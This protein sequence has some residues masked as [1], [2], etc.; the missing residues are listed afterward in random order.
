MLPIYVCEDDKKFLELLKDMILK[1]IAEELDSEAEIVCAATKPSEI[2]TVTEGDRRPALY[3]LDVDLGID[4]MN[5]IELGRNIRVV[6]PGAYIVM[7]TAY[8]DKAYWTYKHRIGAKGYVLK[9][10]IDEVEKNLREHI[11]NAYKALSTN[12]IEDQK[13][14][15]FYD[16][17]DVR[18]K[19][20]NQIYYIEVMQDKRRKL[21]IH[22]KNEVLEAN[23]VLCEIKKQL[24][25]SYFQ[26][27]RSHIVNMHHIKEINAETHSIIMKNGV[28]IPIS[29][30]RYKAFKAH[31][32]EFLEKK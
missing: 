1:I 31:Y 26:C 16:C 22:G 20:A 6:N 15:V 17:G 9:D 19:Y 25:A 10:Q 32:K 29:F 18:T 27:T 14:I 7:V 24:D 23:N 13:I 3:F 4:V 28:K 2:L 21:K 12:Q 11:I 8:A 30:G 5:G